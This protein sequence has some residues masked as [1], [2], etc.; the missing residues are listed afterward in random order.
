MIHLVIP[1]LPPSLNRLLNMH[2]AKRGRIK[3]EWSR[4]VWAAYMEKYGDWTMVPPHEHGC[5]NVLL[6]YY[7]RTNRRRDADNYQKII[8]DALVANGLLV[9][10]SPEW[11]AVHVRFFVNRE[12]PRTEIKIREWPAIG[13]EHGDSAR[14]GGDSA[15]PV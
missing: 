1:A 15:T 10:D 4:L 11:V 12:R 14:S 7:F 13:G 5:R 9:D 2:W 6:E 8:L 3:E